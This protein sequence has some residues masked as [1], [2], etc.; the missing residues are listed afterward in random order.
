MHGTIASMLALERTFLDA[1]LHAVEDPSE[2]TKHV[3]TESLRDL[4]T[5]YQED[6]LKKVA[7]ITDK[8]ASAE[9]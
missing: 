5:M 2:E 8:A 7:A 9:A 3:A 1:L 4:L 6:T